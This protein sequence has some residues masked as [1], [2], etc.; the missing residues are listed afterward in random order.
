MPHHPTP[1]QTTDD[2][3]RDDTNDD[4]STASAGGE[5]TTSGSGDDTVGAG[6]G[7][8]A[9]G[10]SVPDH[11][12]HDGHPAAGETLTGTAGSDHLQGGPGAD[13]LSGGDGDD[14]LRGGDGTDTLDGGAGNDTLVAGDGADVL[15]GG[16][17][18]DLFVIQD[19]VA[20]TEDAL[21][22]IS[23]FTHGEDRLGFE[24]DL[25]LSDGKFATGSADT[26]DAAVALAR[27]DL[28]AGPY[29]VAAIQ[30]GADVIVFAG[31][32]HDHHL[33]SAVVLVG[34]TLADLGVTPAH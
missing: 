17:G 4:T 14:R 33:N 5:A 19:H 2:D 24:G 30:V 10:P 22:R 20:K 23:D 21:P 29:G 13:S 8:T 3:D 9:S 1:S 7:G 31:D 16:Q 15:T 18:H 28:A 6:G 27:S 34:K 32:G 25:S 26:Y 11:V 12:E